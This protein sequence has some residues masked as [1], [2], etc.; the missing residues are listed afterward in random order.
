MGKYSRG[1][2]RV[3]DD[4]LWGANQISPIKTTDL[5]EG[6]IAVS[7]YS[8]SICSRYEFLLRRE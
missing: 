2:V 1:D 4:V 6:I 3:T 7:N 5:Y 8:S